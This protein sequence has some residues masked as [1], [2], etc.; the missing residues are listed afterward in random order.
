MRMYSARARYIQLDGI[1]YWGPCAPYD[2]IFVFYFVRS[3]QFF[4]T[5]SIE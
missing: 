5:T 2:I 4:G 3:A 1:S